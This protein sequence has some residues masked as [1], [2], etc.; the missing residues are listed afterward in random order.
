MLNEG[1][2]FRIYWRRID[3][4]KEFRPSIREIRMQ[5]ALMD[6][7]D[8]DPSNIET[9]IVGDAWLKVPEDVG[10]DGPRVTTGSG[11]RAEVQDDLCRWVA[12][13]GFIT[14]DKK[15]PSGAPSAKMLFVAYSAC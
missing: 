4:L 15:E 2:V 13:P 3:D 11:Q 9:L 10:Y 6:F 14:T 5:P 8:G 7:F 1:L 12:W